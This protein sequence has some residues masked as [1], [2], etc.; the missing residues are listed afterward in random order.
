MSQPNPKQSTPTDAQKLRAFQRLQER[1]NRAINSI[2]AVDASPADIA[3]GTYTSD[4]IGGVIDRQ[5]K[6]QE[7]LAA[8]AEHLHDLDLTLRRPDNDL[9]NALGGKTLTV[10]AKIDYKV[11]TDFTTVLPSDPPP[12]VIDE[13][14]AK[15]IER[16][17]NAWRESKATPSISVV[18]KG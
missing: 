14:E 12:P 3:S 4:E 7:D 18:L 17:H 11:S 10:A 8:N 16:E 9:Q 1:H 5:A 2:A 13:K 15:Q 6:A